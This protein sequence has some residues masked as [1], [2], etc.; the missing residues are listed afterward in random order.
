MS[1][2]I[3]DI[4]KYTL[5]DVK[6]LIAFGKLFSTDIVAIVPSIDK[7][8]ITT[9]LRR[10]KPNI[11]VNYA[12]VLT[13]W[14]SLLVY[15][16]LTSKLLFNITVSFAARLTMVLSTHRSCLKV[17]LVIKTLSWWVTFV[18]MSPDS[19]FIR[20]LLLLQVMLG[21]TVTFV[22][23]H[24]TVNGYSAIITL[25]VCEQF[26]VTG[27]SERRNINKLILCILM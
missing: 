24:V 4:T 23:T 15:L 20:W 10:S 1:A 25:S 8:L 9:F 22:I 14:V 13:N 17:M 5:Y 2:N 16:D 7:G 11:K 27:Y 12:V 26:T 19:D 21:G 6:F 18:V 3:I